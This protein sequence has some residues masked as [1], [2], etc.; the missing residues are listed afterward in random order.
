M[1]CNRKTSVFA[2]LSAA[3]LAAFSVNARAA[4]VSDAFY[5]DLSGG[6]AAFML[7]MNEDAL[8][9]VIADTY[10]GI[11]GRL[12]ICSKG[13]FNLCAGLTGFAA[14]GD[15]TKAVESRMGGG[16]T[17]TDL[18]S[19]GAYVQ[20]KANLGLMTFSPYAGYRQVFGDVSIDNNN[21]FSPADIDTGALFG[22]LESSIKFLPTDLEL[23]ARI[24][25]GRSTG[26][27]G[28][29]DFDYG[30]AS[31]FCAYG[32]ESGRPEQG[33]EIIQ[34]VARDD[35]HKIPGRK[36]KRCH[37][38]GPEDNAPRPKPMRRTGRG[39]GHH[40][41]LLVLS[42][43]TEGQHGEQCDPPDDEIDREGGKQRHGNL[44]S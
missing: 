20:G 2:A 23:G 31:A 37:Q 5:L 28:A 26:D 22:G 32:S 14:L 1:H 12:G 33:G 41:T 9:D 19:I 44:H 17:E 34:P 4:D 15:S 18:S 43:Q 42:A 8:N 39:S 29:A 11:D 30:L 13:P 16:K 21:R 35:H 24:E 36:Q 40:I 7:H 25:Y 38:R 27:S 3:C 6:P 10:W